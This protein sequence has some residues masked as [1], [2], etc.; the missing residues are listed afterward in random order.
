MQFVRG[1]PGGI[2]TRGKGQAL[3]D[4]RGTG[5]KSAWKVVEE[6]SVLETRQETIDYLRNLERI[7]DSD[8][9]GIQQEAH[10]DE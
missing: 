1:T 6:T 2:Q 8:A 5:M 7:D 4:K 10:T 3:I 9:W